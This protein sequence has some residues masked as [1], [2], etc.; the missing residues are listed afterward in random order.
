M[1]LLRFP[2]LVCCIALAGGVA[3]QSPP[4]FGET[5]EVRV[6]NVDFIVT[7]AKGEPVQGLSKDD[8]QIRENGEVREISNFYEI[9]K[10]NAEAAA[11]ARPD[12]SSSHRSSSAVPIQGRRLIFYLDN[13][14]LSPHLRN[15]ILTAAKDFVR[16]VVQE[17]DQ[18]LVATWNRTLA[19]RL[20]WTSDRSRIEGVLDAL[21]KEGASASALSAE[22]RLVDS[23]I[24]QMVLDNKMVASSG[25]TP[26]TQFADLIASARRYAD[27]V[28]NDVQQSL[29]ALTKLLSTLAGVEGRKMLIM[30]SQSLPTR[31][32]SDMFQMIESLQ[33]DPGGADGPGLTTGLRREARRSA[34]LAGEMASFD[35]SKS[36]EALVRAANATGVTIYAMNPEAESATEAGTVEQ[37]GP[38]DSSVAFAITTGGMDGFQIL[39]NGTGGRALIGTKAP[40][41]FA[42]LKKDLDSYY[43]IGYRSSS[44]GDSA[45]RS[46]EVRAKN[47]AHRVRARGSVFYKS[48]KMEMADRVI[49]NHYQDQFSND[50]EITL[51]VA[52]PIR[53]ESGKKFVPLRVFVPVSRLTLLPEGN[54]YVGGFAVYISTADG[55]G[56]VSEVSLQ[57]H[58]IRWPR[59]AYEQLK[60]KSFT[61]ASDIAIE[62][63]RDQVS[64]GVTD[65]VSQQTGFA[66]SNVPA[67]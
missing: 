58:D 6:T 23:Q 13:T 4:N 1:I 7:D 62:Q 56:N 9:K 57:K 50:L 12:S 49:A 14:T 30:A 40:Q 24:G 42:A 61:F 46:I 66:R 2:V 39:S 48:L 38:G 64:V 11:V 36:I 5:V 59:E 43:S 41:A 55:K 47:A 26:P 53:E 60:S 33:N 32:G 19:I 22:R 37:V 21:S 67:Q 54:E 31:P 45:E 10:K 18:V 20:A 8:F 3:A 63:G 17:N 25:R 44:A 65:L 34:S 28:Q 51:G 35:T 29:S 16:G 27:S 15:E 52:G